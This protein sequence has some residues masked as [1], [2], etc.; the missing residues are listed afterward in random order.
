M[1]ARCSSLSSASEAA[2]SAGASRSSRL[3]ERTARGALAAMA[4]AVSSAAA[5]GSSHT[6]VASPMR[7]ASTPS[8]TRPVKVSSRATSARTSRGRRTLSPMS[9]MSP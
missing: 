6:R 5:T 3:A 7:A 9:G 2:T 4:R 8:T 1:S